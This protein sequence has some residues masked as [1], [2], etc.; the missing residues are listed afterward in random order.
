IT[1]QAKVRDLQAALATSERKIV[2]LTGECKIAKLKRHLSNIMVA[3]VTYFLSRYGSDTLECIK[4]IVAGFVC[5]IGKLI[6]AL[7]QANSI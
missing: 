7:T 3:L 6:E 5:F 4:S 2:E 1:S